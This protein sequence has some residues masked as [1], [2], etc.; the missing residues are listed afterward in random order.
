[1]DS[2][3]IG[4]V[5]LLSIRPHYVDRILEGTKRVEFRKAR[6]GRPVTHVIIYSTHPIR[7]VVAAFEVGAVVAAS[8]R[9][10][11]TKYDGVAGI[12]RREFLSYFAESTL[13]VAIAIVNLRI[14]PRPFEL[15]ELSGTLRP[16]QSYRYISATQY[17]RVVEHAV[18]APTS[19]AAPSALTRAVE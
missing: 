17:R 15:R 1:M 19:A 18:E 7:K 8:P 6:F 16:P 3:K 13:A 10:L 12:A 14:L 4:A 11:W 9:R 2:E 5:A